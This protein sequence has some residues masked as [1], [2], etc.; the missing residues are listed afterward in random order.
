MSRS[1]SAQISAPGHQGAVSGAKN[2]LAPIAEVSRPANRLLEASASA[3]H[4]RSH[5]ITVRSG[6]SHPS[7]PGDPPIRSGTRCRSRRA[8]RPAATQRRAVS[9][10]TSLLPVIYQPGPGRRI[11]P[12]VEVL[13]RSD[14]RPRS[15]PCQSCRNN[16]LLPIQDASTP[17]NRLTARPIRSDPLRSR[18]KRRLVPDQ[19]YPRTT[20]LPPPLAANSTCPAILLERN[21]AT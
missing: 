3:D 20:R 11:C 7:C 18:P 17:A 9:P 6:T 16:D 14:Q 13:I 10:P 2:D 15:S 19:P 12:S 8:A 21:S 4:V 1:S 5:P